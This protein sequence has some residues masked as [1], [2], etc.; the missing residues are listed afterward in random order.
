MDKKLKA[1]E[2]FFAW[3][4]MA[5]SLFVF[6]QAF[7]IS[8]FSSISS[9]GTFPMGAAAVMILSM[10]IVLVS[11]YRRPK[12]D[13]ESIKEELQLAAASVLPRIFLVY[14]A[15]IIIYMVLI[16]P[17]RFLPSSFAFLLGSML[18]LKGSRPLKAL[19]IASGTMAGIYM[20]FQYVFRVVLP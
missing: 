10:G 19:L 9:P 15:V 13:A 11:N 1:G 2:N 12:P 6:F 20:I 14:I 5:F 16:E 8:G 3:L 17:L 7:R 4:L 18:Y